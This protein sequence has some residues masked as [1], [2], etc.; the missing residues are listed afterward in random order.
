MDIFEYLPQL[1]IAYDSNDKFADLIHVKKADKNNDYYCP[2]CG[3]TVKPRALES[4]KEQSHYYHITGKCTKE[5]QLHF[6][7]KNWLFEAGSKFYIEDK[8]FEVYSVDIEKTH[9]T[10]FGGYRPDVTVHTVCGKT[11]YFEMFFSNR[12]VGDDY[13]CKWEFLGNG[14]VEVNIKEYMFKT[15]ENVIPVFKYLYHDGVCYSKTYI[16][17]DLYA[18][19]I[20]KIKRELSRQQILNYKARIEQLDWFWKAVQEHSSKEKILESILCMDYGDMVSCYGIVRRKHCMSHLKEDILDAINKKVVESVRKKLNLPFDRNV[21]FDLKHHGG[22]TYEIGIRLNIRLSHIVFEDF[23]KRCRGCRDDFK[24]TLGYPKVVFKKNIFSH[25]EIE[26]QKKE[27]RE[28]R[29]IFNETVEYKEELIRYNAKLRNFE[30]SGAYRIR[31]K[32]NCYTILQQLDD[33]RCKLLLEKKFQNLLGIDELHSVIKMSIEDSN[34]DGFLDRI[35]KDNKYDE[36]MK[37]YKDYCGLQSSLSV[38]YDKV[39][40]CLCV[41]LWIY[42]H[43]EFSR[44]IFPDDADFFA[45]LKECGDRL[46]GFISKY[47]IAL[48]LSGKIK[49]CKN[50]IW[51]SEFSFDYYG[52]F[53][54]HIYLGMQEHRRIRRSIALSELDL[55]E[56]SN[57]M[58]RIEKEMHGLLKDMEYHGCRI[59]FEGGENHEE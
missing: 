50:K 2:C 17:K 8:L 11:I 27:A 39:H 51:D 4:T 42:G 54:L 55:A 5:S 30:D 38:E 34:A 13:F 9:D 40:K 29:N 19:T 37:Q 3:G 7:C 45:A 59:W 12:K 36:A 44:M 15:D 26:I 46:D 52:R 47:H 1:L 10:Q 53:M 25:E 57:I 33:G 23:Y 58:P 41:N 24:T 49:N 14:V 6:F 43:K 21:Y 22:R 32:N 20:A 28:L 31:I 56:K 35:K 48:D 16:K 18:N